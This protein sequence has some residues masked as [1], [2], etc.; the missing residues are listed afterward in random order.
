MISWVGYSCF[1]E[2]DSLAKGAQISAQCYFFILLLKTA[3]SPGN[4]IP[5]LSV[6]KHVY[7]AVTAAQ[8]YGASLQQPGE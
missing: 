8:M 6:F 3:L 1:G 4:H 2:D 7:S 5:L